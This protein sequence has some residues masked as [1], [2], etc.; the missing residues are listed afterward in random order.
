[1]PSCGTAQDPVLRAKFAGEP[2]HVI[3]FLFMVAEEMREYMADMGFA[4]VNDMV[5]RADM[6][7]VDQAVIDANPKLKGA[8]PLFATV[9]EHFLNM[10]VPAVHVMPVVG[11]LQPQV[12]LRDR[13]E[14]GGACNRFGAGID[15]SRLLTPAATLR[16]E[17]AQRCVRRQDHGLDEGLDL[18]VLI[19][20]C[21]PALPP[22]APRR[23]PSTSRPPSATPTGAPLPVPVC[24]LDVPSRPAGC[25]LFCDSAAAHVDAAALTQTALPLAASQTLLPFQS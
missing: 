16:P 23:S 5:G 9:L 19:P 21:A 17:A 1:M 24:L 7:E 3:N 25:L 20:A 8:A 14:G 12:V 15:L 4:T 2:E 11:R 18:P 22:T 10:A 13:P 6:M